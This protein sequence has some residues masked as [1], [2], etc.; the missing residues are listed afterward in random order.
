VAERV[1]LTG[2]AGRIGTCL[3]TGLR[4]GLRE[5][6]LSD[7][8]TLRAEHDAETVV[9]ADLADR[10]AVARA[11]EGVDA[12]VHL[13]GEPGEADLEALLDPNVRGV[14]H[15]LDAARRAGV[16]RVVLA[17]SNHVTGF[18]AAGVPLKGGEPVRPDSLYGVTK[19]FGEALGRMYVDKFGL[20]VVC[21]RIGTFGE[22]PTTARHL[23]TW[24][25][26]GDTVRLVSACLRAPSPLG[27][28]VLYGAS[29]N[30][31][32]WWDLGPARRL[33]YAPQ[34]D[35]EAFA[36]ELGAPP[37]GG[38]QGAEFAER[39]YGGWTGPGA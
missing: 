3:R 18:Y 5:L 38:P 30:T 10:E 22:R 6:R 23:A 14:F 13:G 37:A 9:A 17:S 32:G 28:A 25:S 7:R 19:A 33:G 15:V 35:S 11:A 12:V 24:L 8:A 4:P 20:E 2:A 31:R 27:F 39:G 34:D 26:P 1:L 16:R 21:L 36:G 29:A